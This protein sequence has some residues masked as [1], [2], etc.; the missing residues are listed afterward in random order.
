MIITVT[1]SAWPW[2]DIDNED[3]SPMIIAEHTFIT[4]AWPWTD[5][6]NEDKSPMNIA[7]HTLTTSA[8]P[9]PLA[10]SKASLLASDEHAAPRDNRYCTSD[11]GV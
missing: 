7:E 5:I 3:K 2:T 6:D 1:T 8:W 10:S 4:S 9:L 11:R